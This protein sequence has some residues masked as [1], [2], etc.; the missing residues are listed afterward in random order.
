MIRLVEFFLL[1][2]P[3]WAQ[4]S[5]DPDFF[6]QRI[7][8]IF[9]TKCQGC[10]GPQKAM[11]GLNLSTA[12]A[13]MKGSDRGPI[14]KKG[15]AA[16]SRLIEVTSYE[17]AVKMPPTGKLTRA[18]LDDLRSWIAMGAPWP[19]EKLQTAVQLV[20][21]AGGFT[22]EQRSH[23]AFQP[24][25]KVAAPTVRNQSWAKNDIDR[26][27]LAKLEAEG[28]RPS[29]SASK[30]AL[31]RR[32]TFDLTGLP[33]T[34]AEIAAFLSDDST[35]AY[36]RVVDRLLA[37]PHYGEKWGRRWLDI[38]RYADS[39]GMDEDHPYP[40][41]WRYRDYVID[42]FNRD[43]PYDRFICEQLA[44]DLLPF[45]TPE[46]RNRNLIATGFLALGPKPL[47]QQD[48][49]K[50]IYDVV[51]EQIDV[52]SKVFMGLTVACA[53]CHDH[54]FDPILTK[55]YYS[56]ASIFASTKSFRNLGRPSSVAYLYYASLDPDAYRRREAHRSRM[57]AKQMEMED[58]L[59]DEQAQAY[60]RLRPH[61]AD[62]LV[63]AWK[64]S[65]EGAQSADLASRQQLDQPILE[66]W[67]RYVKPSDKPKP[68]LRKWREADDSTIQSVARDYEA[69]YLKT[70][71]RWDA[72]LADWRKD[73]A[74]EV[75]QDRDLPARPKPD[76]PERE[77]AAPLKEEDPFFVETSFGDGPFALEESPRVAALRE[78]WK[79]LEKTLP[80][81][82]PMASAVTDE[83]LP[84]HQTVFIRG[85][86]NSPGEAVEKRFPRIL[87]G[88]REAPIQSISGR[89]ELAAW[90]SRP[91]HPLTARV[92]VNRIWQWHF[93][94][95]V[96][97]TPSN[98]GKMGESPTH[99]ELLDYLASRFVE[100]GWSVKALHRMILLSSSYQMSS[101]SSSEARQKDPANRL[102]SHF[103]RRRLDVEEIRDSFLQ[104]DGSLELAM[105]GTLMEGGRRRSVNVDDV[106]R[107]T[108]Y[109][110]VRR[111]SMP[112][113]L[114]IFDFGDAT[115]S[116]EARSRTNV[117]PQALFMLNSPLVLARSRGFAKE[118]LK[119]SSSDLERL[120][121]AFLMT[122]TRKPTVDEVQRA[123]VYIAGLKNKL[124]SPDALEYAWQS[125]CQILM[126]S[127][128][129]AYLD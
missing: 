5:G 34:T 68:H 18:E 10:H 63:A 75:R 93:G 126:A 84:V 28:L 129:F 80:P 33:P 82:P 67:N 60:S 101:A 95:A 91:D 22:S 41:A 107:R 113:L 4:P 98:W 104:M 44:G 6:E 15:D 87:G 94:D 45:K 61:L 76:A 125:Y 13:F 71:A 111:G 112:V 110:P 2:L 66:K 62:Y 42:A 21:R 114:A 78:A 20:A 55:D 127:N 69:V 14:V 88:D 11:A 32:V 51:D 43:L 116:N 120:E 52:T 100:S 37:S 38:A 26:F 65:R 102:W 9:A 29:P 35:D 117:P 72:R 58:A 47:A 59:A 77:F 74:E 46:E 16:H 24:I 53:R 97:R 50:M 108:I 40:Y 30:L 122:L 118:L 124:A 31:L 115:A 92:M 36:A 57:Y 64:V 73:L 106:Q 96:V 27:I 109:L 90:L 89:L 121:R 86:H 81:E 23:W 7:R 85:D 128:E 25:K 56:L 103:N 99:P 48:R 105:G 19:E 12:A 54:K 119:A 123:L 83:E 49:R 8:P 39:T 3:V 79:Q 70:A 1:T 17:S